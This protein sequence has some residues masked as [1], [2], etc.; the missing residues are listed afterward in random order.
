M[1]AEGVVDILE[2]IEVHQQDG[3]AGP[4]WTCQHLVECR[5]QEMPVGK[6]GKNVVGSLI[7][8]ALLHLLLLRYIPDDELSGGVASVGN[9]Y[10]NHLQIGFDGST[11]EAS[12]VST[13]ETHGTAGVDR[14]R[15]R[16]ADGIIVTRAYKAP[17]LDPRQITARRAAEE[18]SGRG[19]GVGNPVVGNQ[20]DGVGCHLHQRPV[21]LFALLERPR[22]LNRRGDVLGHRHDVR[23]GNLVVDQCYGCPSPDDTPALVEVALDELVRPNLARKDLVVLREIDV[24][25]VGVGHISPRPKSKLARGVAQHLA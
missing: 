22:V 13:F 19:V 5:Q 21:A 16:G 23:L 6:S 25:I 15:H 7:L 24:Q 1:V 11:I 9:R 4:R 12:Q 8:Q 17:R 20:Q 18:F 10:A 3:E 14:G 2:S